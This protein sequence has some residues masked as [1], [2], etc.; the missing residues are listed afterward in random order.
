M[1]AFISDPNVTISPW[2]VSSGCNR[3]RVLHGHR[4]GPLQVYHLLVQ[5]LEEKIG[6]IRHARSVLRQHQRS[7]DVKNDPGRVLEKHL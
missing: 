4:I 3:R 1:L 5:L 7:C 6:G 2:D